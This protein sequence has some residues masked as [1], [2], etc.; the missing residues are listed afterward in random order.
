[1]GRN[2]ISLFTSNSF[3]FEA[4]V[5][6]EDSVTVNYIGMDNRTYAQFYPTEPQTVKKYVTR[7]LDRTNP[8]RKDLQRIFLTTREEDTDV[9]YLHFEYK[10][11]LLPES[12]NTIS[13]ALGTVF[14]EN[15]SNNPFSLDDDTIKSLLIRIRSENTKEN[16][17][18]QYEITGTVNTSERERYMREYSEV[19]S[20][21]VAN[22]NTGS[23]GT[24]VPINMFAEQLYASKK[25]PLLEYLHEQI[26]PQFSATDLSPQTEIRSIQAESWDTMYLT[27]NHLL[28]YPL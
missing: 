13:T 23:D 28:P 7:V 9:P 22:S 6:T 19:I 1:M 16:T 4:E 12:V 11:Q 25:T 21:L 2:P 17:D 20:Q 15:Y 27:Y 26:S 8:A 3:T 5:T 14:Q 24:D 10:M 18:D